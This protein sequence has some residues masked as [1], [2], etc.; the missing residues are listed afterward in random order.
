MTTD[1]LFRLLLGHFVGDYLLQN[2][3]MA[4]N[5]KK[6]GLA[7]TVHC[8]IWT[9]CI[10]FACIPELFE[11]SLISF[12]KY[13]GVIFLIYWSHWIFD[14]TNIVDNW[15]DFIGGRSYRSADIYCTLIEPNL[16]PDA[17]KG[18]MKAYTALVQTIADNTLHF[19][20]LYLIFR[21]L[22]F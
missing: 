21:I 15:L 12:W 11:V 9:A 2:N 18:Y 3:W 5:K 20:C 22:V 6:K 7:T 13:W 19:L 1:F 16:H 8:G 10:V 4:L 17:V 14:A